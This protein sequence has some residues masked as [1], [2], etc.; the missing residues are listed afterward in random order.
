MSLQAKKI[1]EELF[2]QCWNLARHGQ[3]WE[4]KQSQ[5]ET[6]WSSLKYKSFS[7]RRLSACGAP[8]RFWPHVRVRVTSIHFFK[9]QWCKHMWIYHIR[10]IPYITVYPLWFWFE[11]LQ[12]QDINCQTQSRSW[13]VL[14]RVPEYRFDA[15][16]QNVQE[17]PL[18]PG[19]ECGACRVLRFRACG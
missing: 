8:Q 19:R 13:L 1:D 16:L 5:H 15:E 3:P 2:E 14:K 6:H 10:M 18:P 12:S 17:W 4:L 9:R 11:A 7:S